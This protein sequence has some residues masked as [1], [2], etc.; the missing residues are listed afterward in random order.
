MI[1][2]V[3][4]LMLSVAGVTLMRNAL[5]VVDQGNRASAI[6]HFVVAG[7]CFVGA[8]R[9][10]WRWRRDTARRL[11]KERSVSQRRAKVARDAEPG[12]SAAIAPSDLAP[13][14]TTASEESRAQ[15]R[16][17]AAKARRRKT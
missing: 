6:A 14:V 4:G 1:H 15:R 16:A 2:L 10:W 11:S 3:A 7:A 17:R 9:A 12:A 13:T 5:A 8:A